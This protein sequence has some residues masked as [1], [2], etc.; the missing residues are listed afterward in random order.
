MALAYYAPPGV[1]PYLDVT[2][3]GLPNMTDHVS[4]GLQQLH[5]CQAARQRS[6]ALPPLLTKVGFTRA[7]P[8]LALSLTSLPPSTL[9]SS[10]QGCPVRR[11]E[12]FQLHRRRWLRAVL[13]KVSINRVVL[14]SDS[15]YFACIQL[16]FLPPDSTPIHFD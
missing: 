5:P 4:Q 8:W 11:L 14:I 1:Y 12:S 16:C 13:R 10:T 3:R 7:Q 15:P 6:T 9:S 2:T